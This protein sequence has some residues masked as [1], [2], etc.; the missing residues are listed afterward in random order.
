MYMIPACEI[1][2]VLVAVVLEFVELVASVVTSAA[3]VAAV[4][5]V[6]FAFAAGVLVVAFWPFADAINNK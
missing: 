6:V 4:A 5:S 3:A 1:A 2:A